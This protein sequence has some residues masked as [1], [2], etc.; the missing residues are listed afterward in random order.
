M[1]ALTGLIANAAVVRALFAAHA[2]RSFIGQRK[3]AAASASFLTALVLAGLEMCCI[4][5]DSAKLSLT[6][7]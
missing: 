3:V 5:V 6:R 7:R 2:Y 4:P 1:A